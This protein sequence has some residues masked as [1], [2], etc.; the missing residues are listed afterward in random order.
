MNDKAKRAVLLR[1]EIA[2]ALREARPEGVEPTKK[3]FWFNWPT[4]DI[5]KTDLKTAGIMKEDELGRVVNFHSFYK[6]WQTLGVRY[7]I[8]QRAAQELLGHSARV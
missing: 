7:G 6:T 5:L 1:A 2:A 8:N 3:V 4:Y